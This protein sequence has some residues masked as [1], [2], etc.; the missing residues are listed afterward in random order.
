MK[1]LSLKQPYAV[2]LATGKKTIEIRKWNTNFRGTFLIHA[3]KNVN[4]D[5]CSA[6]GFDEYKLVKG[7]IIGKAFVYDVIK[8]TTKDIFLRDHQ[9]HF[10]IEDINSNQSF[11]RYGFLV[12]DHLEFGEEIPYLGKLGFFE[13]SDL[14]I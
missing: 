9:K 4:R 1:C 3:S 2:L 6:L 14:S 13:V 11:K 12:K 5:A 8:Y 10:S 7:A